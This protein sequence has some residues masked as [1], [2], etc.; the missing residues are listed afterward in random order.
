MPQSPFRSLV[1]FQIAGPM[2][3]LAAVLVAL[4]AVAAW[5]V[6]ELQQTNNDVLAREVRGMVIDQDL[7]MEMREIRYQVNLYLRTKSASHLANVEQI[8]ER[9]DTLLADALESARTDREQELVAV[10]ERGYRGFFNAFQPLAAAAAMRPLTQAEEAELSRL[11]DVVLTDVL[12]PCRECFLLN[13]EVV[14]RTNQA[15]RG[16][17]RTLRVGF[18]LL[19]ICGGIAGLLMGVG[20]ARTVGRGVVQLDVTVRDMAGRLTDGVRPVT[21]LRTGDIH[22]LEDGLRHL[23]SHIG[24][25]LERL[26]QR[27]HELL[28]S[29]QLAQVGQLAAGMA[30]ELRNPLMPIK[31]LVQGALERGETAGLT[32][33]SLHVLDDEIGR[34][35]ESIQSFLDFARP[36]VPEKS[37]TNLVAVAENAIDLVAPR[38]RQ[39]QAEIRCR[40][41]ERGLWA[42]VDAGQMRQLLL[43]LLL[44]AL[45][46]LQHG[47]WIEVLLTR[48]DE[49]LSPAGA[50]HEGATLHDALR[51]LAEGSEGS[52]AHLVIRVSDNGPGIPVDLASRIFE[53]FVTSKE[54][55]TGLGLS[56]CQRIAESHQGDIRY[57]PRPGGGAVFEVRLPFVSD[58]PHG[59]PHA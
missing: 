46:A 59:P 9:T 7:Y 4:A 3:A 21:F 32:G 36:P 10:V 18:L 58:P 27:E 31:M 8:H 44:N 34:L 2:V 24:T 26:Q 53:P 37:P 42:T 40:L 45:D 49:P 20:I 25:M 28:R 39:Q 57:F 15:A 41:P 29:E 43:N 54:T 17:A 48:I 51:I 14:D 52:Q 13:Q 6:H 35:E 47:G 23:E 22:D 12:Q 19:G 5:K 38:A 30:H 55:G 33:R 56:I 1:F 50:D 16:S 11:A